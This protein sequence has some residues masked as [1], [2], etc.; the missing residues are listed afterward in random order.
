[1]GSAFAVY[2]GHRNLEW[3]WVKNMPSPLLWR[4]LPAHLTVWVF[5]LVYFSLRGRGA[6]IWKAKAAGLLGMGQVLAARRQ[7]QHRRDVSTQAVAALL[8]RSSLVSR[9]FGTTRP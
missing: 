1:V 3:V 4:H 9:F 5:S 2:H 6:S 8:D 7:V